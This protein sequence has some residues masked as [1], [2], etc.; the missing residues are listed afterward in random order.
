MYH[1]DFASGIRDNRP[2]LDS[3]LRTLLKGDVL[4]VWK[5]DRLGRNL[6]HLVARG[7]VV[8]VGG[9]VRPDS[10]CLCSRVSKACRVRSAQPHPRALAT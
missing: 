3:C 2:E 1:D 10:V 4:V 8:V 5:L 7:G 9:I 6:A